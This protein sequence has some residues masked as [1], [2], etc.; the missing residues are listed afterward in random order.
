MKNPPTISGKET[1]WNQNVTI[2]FIVFGMSMSPRS[3]YASHLIHLAQNSLSPSNSDCAA[4][5]GL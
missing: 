4:V 2:A 5:R 3:I 1:Q